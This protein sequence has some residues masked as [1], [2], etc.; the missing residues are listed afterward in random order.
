[1]SKF[2]KRKWGFPVRFNKRGRVVEINLYLYEQ[3]ELARR[4]IQAMK[5]YANGR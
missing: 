3:V 1:M 2:K 5:E 4:N